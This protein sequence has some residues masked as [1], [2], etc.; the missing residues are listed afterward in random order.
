MTF[1]VVIPITFTIIIVV[2]WDVQF[3]REKAVRVGL[4]GRTASVIQYELAASEKRLCR[5]LPFDVIVRSVQERPGV[6][7]FEYTLW[8]MSSFHLCKMH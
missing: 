1:A 3:A 5:R 4:A 6:F 2:V 8:N 7:F